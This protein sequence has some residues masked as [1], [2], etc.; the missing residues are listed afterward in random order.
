MDKHVG[1]RFTNRLRTRYARGSVELRKNSSDTLSPMNATTLTNPSAPALDCSHP[2]RSVVRIPPVRLEHLHE[3]VKIIG[4]DP[5][6]RA[7]T[8]YVASGANRLRLKNC[9]AARH[10]DLIGM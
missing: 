1:K 9:G 3:V 6:A 8:Q 4:P 2:G 10:D 5:E 7:G